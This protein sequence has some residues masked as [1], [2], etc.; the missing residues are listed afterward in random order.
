MMRLPVFKAWVPLLPLVFIMLSPGPRA[1]GDE[2]A[3][4]T[5]ISSRGCCAAT[6]GTG[7]KIIT[8]QG[9]TH[10]GWLDSNEDGFFDVV[11]TLDRKT[12]QW[13]PAY[14]LGKAN[15]DHGRPA[16]TIDS[17]GYLHAVY[18]IHHNDVPYCRSLRPNDASEWTDRS[19]FGGGL[20]YPTLVCG[21]DDTLFLTGRDGWSGVRLF[22]KPPGQ[23]WEDRGLIIKVNDDCISYAAF[24]EGLAW[25][26][27]HKTLHL[28]C[29]FFQ[30]TSNVSQDWGS[31]QSVNY[32][33]SR[34][35]GRTWERADGTRIEVPATAETMDVLLAGESMDPKPGIRNTGAI[36]VDSQGRP[37]VLYYRNTPEKPGQGFLAKADSAGNWQQ[38]PLQA[39]LDKHFPG[40]AIVDCRAGFTITADDR[41]C[42]ALSLV[43]IDHPQADWTGKPTS[44][45]SNEP[46]Y[47]QNFY[48]TA[49]RIRWLE[50]S[51]GGQTFSTKNLLAEDPEI[52][53][54]QQSIE[55]PTGFN[56]IPAGSY[57][58]LIYHTGVSGN[59]EG[60]L[61]DNDVFFVHVE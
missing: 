5:L 16:L 30:S 20:S 40:E 8:Y 59:R 46:A 52:A 29:S 56:Q 58:G 12:G 43:P 7:N 55:M 57:P 60:K 53:Q 25:G 61:I 48:P 1:I 32:M 2:P 6:A 39:A 17:Q 15:G 33:R 22:V 36:V 3:K 50:S 13:S 4:Q 11:R 35:F 34:D 27:D 42:M 28:S 23:P 41:L 24:H 44:T 14:T 38:L 19:T 37:Y 49:K 54:L 26:P 21:P 18:G 51:D 47:W 9:K 31:I 45:H 10:V